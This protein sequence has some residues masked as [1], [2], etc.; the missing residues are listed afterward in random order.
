MELDVREKEK[1]F[2]R[3]TYSMGEWVSAESILQI[4]KHMQS[5]GLGEIEAMSAYLGLMEIDVPD[6][7]P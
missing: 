7:D 2:G 1:I 3:G 5:I 6:V 4:L